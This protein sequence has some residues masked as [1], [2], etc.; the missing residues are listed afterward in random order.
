MAPYT[1]PSLVHQPTCS[2]QTVSLYIDYVMPWQRPP[3]SYPLPCTSIERVRL[4]L[5]Y[6]LSPS[7][8]IYPSLTPPLYSP[9]LSP[10]LY[11]LLHYIST[12]SLLHYIPHPLSP[13]LCIPPSPSL[14]SRLLTYDP[15]SPLW[16]D[17]PCTTGYLCELRFCGTMS[18]G[19]VSTPRRQ[20]YDGGKGWST[21]G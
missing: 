8:F 17:H 1:L 21:V 7:L 19:R 14:A 2:S 20:L 15:P 3:T 9:S 5:L 12:P 4:P 18:G 11:S 6:T 10:S 16:Y 13:S